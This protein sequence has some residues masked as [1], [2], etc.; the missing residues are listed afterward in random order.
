MRGKRT[1]EAGTIGRPFHVSV[2]D[3]APAWAAELAEIFSK[4]RPLVGRTASAAVVPAWRGRPLS[5]GDAAFAALVDGGAEE[6]LLHG[7]SHRR[8]DGR[9]VV[10]FLTGG[11]DEFAGLPRGEARARLLRGRDVVK[12]LFGRAAEGFLAPAFQDGA[13]DADALSGAGLS[14]RVGWAS[15]DAVDGRSARLATRIWD[16]SPL[17]ALSRVGEAVGR[18]S[19]LRRGAVPTIAVH[20]LDVRRGFLPRAVRAV[21]DLL[22]AGR[23]PVLLRD[24][25]AGVPR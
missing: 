5:P 8:E 7:W 20:P 11:A 18:L 15:V 24:I 4:L 2:H 14:Y 9:G 22:A 3:A 13:V 12:A 1:G 25:V 21:E 17:A 19:E 6:L 16:V 23:T 10:S